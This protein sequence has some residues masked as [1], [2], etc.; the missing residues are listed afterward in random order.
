MSALGQK[1]TYAVQWW[2]SRTLKADSP[3]LT[4]PRTSSDNKFELS[5][6]AVYTFKLFM[7]L[8]YFVPR[9]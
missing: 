5:S 9:F 7:T 2:I 6:K 3:N 8:V 4:C 1:Q